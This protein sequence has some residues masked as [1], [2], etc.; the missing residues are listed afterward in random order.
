MATI[1]ASFLIK[2]VIASTLVVFLLSCN[3]DLPVE[4]VAGTP[5]VT[6][7]PSP[8]GPDTGISYQGPA[9]CDFN[10][11]GSEL[12]RAGWK[13]EFEDNFDGDLAKWD[14]WTGGG[15]DRELQFYQPANALTANGVLQISAKKENVTG[16]TSPSN[17][18]LK[19]YKY[20]SARI[21]SKAKFSANSGTPKVRIAARIKL[22]GG[23]GMVPVFLSYGTPWPTQGHINML[24]ADGQAPKRYITNYFYGSSPNINTVNNSFGYITSDADLTTCYHV[25]E[26][27]W[28][29]DA[30][31]FFLDGK[32]VEKKTSGGHIPDLFG[33]SQRLSLYLSVQTDFIYRTK[34]EPRTMTVDWIKVFTSK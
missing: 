7:S 18:A 31:T 33:K 24:V 1:K 5:G 23:F 11:D 14:S 29:Q 8:S 30:L 27:E 26:M 12:I 32:L 15:N 28:S 21:E 25:Y 16:A 10:P 22:P 20:T 17:P 2:V 4:E 13:L 19:N 34:I 9:L 3:K 6:P